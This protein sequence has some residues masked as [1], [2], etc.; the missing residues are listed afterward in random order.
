MMCDLV[1]T[2]LLVFCHIVS[3]IHIEENDTGDQP[4]ISD[5]AEPVMTKLVPEL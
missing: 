1:A 4:A 2:L 3:T 5:N